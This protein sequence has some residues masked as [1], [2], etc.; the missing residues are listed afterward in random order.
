MRRKTFGFAVVFGVLISRIGYSQNFQTFLNRLYSVPIEAK[1]ALVDSF[2][3]AQKAFPV[4]ES[5]SIV[6]FIFTGEASSVTIP[7][8]ANQWDANADRM[9]RVYGTNFWYLT[10]KYE[11]DARLDYKFVINGSN[12]IL[13]PRNPNTCLGGFGPNSELRMPAYQFPNEIN[14]RANIP[15]GTFFDTTFYSQ[16]LQN[17]RQIRVYLPP[18]YPQTADSFGVALFHDGLEFVSL[19]YANN[20]LDYLIWQKTIKPVIAV[21]IPPVNRTAEYA[22]SLRGKFT[23]FIVAEVLPWLTK[24]YKIYRNPAWHA[25]VGASNGGNIALWLAVSHP[26]IFG[27][28]AAF[29]SN[30]QSD[31]ANLVTTSPKLPVQFYLDIGTYDISVL[32]PLVRNMK[33]L[34]EE[35]GYPLEYHEWHEGHSWGNWRAHVDNVLLQFF[36]N[37]TSIESPPKV[38]PTQCTVSNYPNPF[39]S[40]TN[41]YFSLP[42]NGEVSLKIFDIQGRLITNLITEFLPKGD[43][44]LPWIPTQFPSG[45]YIYQ[46]RFRQQIYPGKLLYFK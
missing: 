45:I 7:G 24:K 18:D 44:Y 15:H 26:E 40:Q 46:L 14:Y 34:L 28:V 4:I 19:A 42:Q 1:A 38:I 8:D 32:I 36:P 6:N 20:V 5:D 9:S 35:R 10:K 27:K 29:S 41:F 3:A 25:T 2:L 37:S 13:D 23:D 17:S 31:I 33:S 39:N 21:F 12:W 11:P 22:G 43:Y 16:N 30:V